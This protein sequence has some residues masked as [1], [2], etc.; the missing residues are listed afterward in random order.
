M[1]AGRSRI[2][3]LPAMAPSVD[4]S[5]LLLLLPYR[6]SF[7]F[8]KTFARL[9]CIY[10]DTRKYHIPKVRLAVLRGQAM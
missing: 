7:W 9:T 3:G 1:N 10:G 5:S 2:I 8:A 6:E 4:L